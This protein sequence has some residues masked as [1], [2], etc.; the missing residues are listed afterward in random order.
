SRFEDILLG[1]GTVAVVLT[2]IVFPFVPG[3]FP[4]PW[5]TFA[6][7]LLHGGS[8][9]PNIL[10]IHGLAAVVLYSIV[11]LAAAHA[12]FP[13][14]RMLFFGVGVAVA[15]LAGFVALQ[16]LSSPRLRVERAYIA[17]VY[18]CRPGSLEAVF[19]P[20]MTIPRSLQNRRV[21][22]LTVPPFTCPPVH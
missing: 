18:L 17:D 1:F 12:V 16:T 13:K 9:I 22:E 2:T 5:G 15:L 8:V 20:G 6:L 21:Y 10:G 11:V 14:G 4:L 3:E 19:P 7:A